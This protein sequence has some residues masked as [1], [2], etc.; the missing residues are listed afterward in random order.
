MAMSRSR[1]ILTLIL[2]H[3]IIILGILVYI[4]ASGADYHEILLVDD[5]YYKSAG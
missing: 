1:Y 2:I 4:I 3:T 5:G